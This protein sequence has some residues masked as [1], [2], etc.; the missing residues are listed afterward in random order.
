MSAQRL[1]LLFAD[2]LQP[3]Q[4]TLAQWDRLV[5][6]ARLG[7][8]ASLL[9]ARYEAAGALD[10]LPAP[11]A[12]QLR[13]ERT[14][15]EY[16]IRMTRWNLEHLV[17]VLGPLDIELVLLKGAAYVAQDVPWGRG[18][19]TG[20]V[21]LM[22]RASQIPR[23][24]A[25]LREAG[26]R[27]GEITD[28]D[29]RYYREWSH[30]L[31][32]L[33]HPERPLPI[34]LHHTI[35]PVTGRL[36][37]D[38]DALVDASVA[39]PDGRL[40]VLAPEDQVLHTCCHLF[41]D[42]DMWHQLRDLLDLDAMLREYGR[43]PDFDERLAA[44]VARHGLHRPLHYGLRYARRYL[45]SPM[46]ERARREAARH[47]QPSPPTEWLMDALVARSLF[48]DSPDMPVRASRLWAKRALKARQFARR[49]PPRLLAR[50]LWTK[51]VRPSRAPA[52]G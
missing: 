28:Y 5:R 14:V 4:P 42:S 49:F 19:L 21:D 45:G 17:E 30:E 23:A 48:P 51:W 3:Q 41:E 47:A 40:R 11:V 29:E 6:I 44:S 20:D 16:R 9:H 32:P 35:L 15:A 39:L 24:E 10:A 50:H 13:S 36:R 25:A 46:P 43:G 37:P 38:G 31:P 2:P 33:M 18:R 7:S 22:V 12:R 52:L 27:F 34:D 1:L 26:W 8:V